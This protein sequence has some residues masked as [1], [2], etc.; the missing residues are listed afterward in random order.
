MNTQRRAY[1]SHIKIAILFSIAFFLQGCAETIVVS[2]MGGLIALNQARTT[3]SW[4]QDQ[5][6]EKEARRIL[7]SNDLLRDGA[8]ISVVSYNQ[9]VL[10]TGQARTKSLRSHADKL[11]TKIPGVRSVS[12]EVLVVSRLNK[13]AA[14]KD[15]S[16]ATRIKTKLFFNDL[17][18]TQVKVVTQQGNVYL[19]GMVSKQESEDVVAVV[20]DVEGIRKV[21]K[22]FEYVD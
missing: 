19:M 17:D 3:K 2:G 6:I 1:N 14:D 16:L 13:K 12:N 7:K 4:Y 18:G 9:K 22:M 15:S 8:D 21:T 20:S 10:M 11:I 5:S